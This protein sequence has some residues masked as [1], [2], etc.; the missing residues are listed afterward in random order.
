MSTQFKKIGLVVRNDMQARQDSIRQVFP[1]AY[2]LHV[3]RDPR[4]TC[5]SMLRAAKAWENELP[6]RVIHVANRWNEYMRRADRLRESTDR[7]IEVRYEDLKANG[8]SELER[9]G[10]GLDLGVDAET[11]ARAIEACAL[12]RMQKGADLPKGFFPVYD[13]GINYKTGEG[14]PDWTHINIAEFDLAV[15]KSGPDWSYKGDKV[16]Y[17]YEV[18][19]AGPASVTRRPRSSSMARTRPDRCPQM[20]SS[21]TRSVPFFTRKTLL[22]VPSTS[23]SC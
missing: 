2:F 15:E 13:K 6:G 9:I 3:I 20:K 18:T 21:P 8:V 14:Y 11:C 1:D 23:L 16:T 12:E 4:D 22:M 19:N 7:Y 10:Q 17:T 5:V